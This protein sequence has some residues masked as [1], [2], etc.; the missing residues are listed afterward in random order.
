MERT[1]CLVPNPP[2]RGDIIAPVTGLKLFKWEYQRN[3][4]KCN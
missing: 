2:H 1:F 3:Q 4:K